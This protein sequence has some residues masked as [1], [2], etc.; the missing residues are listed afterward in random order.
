MEYFIVNMQRRFLIEDK[1]L[2]HANGEFVPNGK[3]YF[4]R[5]GKGEVILDAP[6]FDYF[7]L[8]SFGKKEDWEWRLQDVHGFIAVGSIITGWYVSDKF[9]K[10]MECFFIAGGYHFYPTKL[11]Y[12]GEKLDYWIFLYA[13]GAI[14]NIDFNKS[15]FKIKNEEEIVPILSWDNYLL[16]IKTL[17]SE[18]QKRIELR[19]ITFVE[20][21]DLVFNII[22]SNILV[23]KK[24]KTELENARLVGL[25]FKI[26]DYSVQ[27]R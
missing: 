4:D 11:L 21:F 17:R 2:G 24:I 22:D 10:L 5:M 25:E 15:V 12:K 9:K 20:T 27:T 16:T 26:L 3:H 18:R 23:S 14:Q 7:H 8:Q 19:S 13:I 1:V 6:L